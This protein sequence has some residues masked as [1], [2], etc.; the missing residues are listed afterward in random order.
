[1]NDA[2][3]HVLQTLEPQY[4]SIKAAMDEGPK[5]RCDLTRL[6]KSTMLQV[7]EYWDDGIETFDVTN[8]SFLFDDYIDW[9]EK[10]LATWKH[11]R[12]MSWDQWYFRSHKDAEKFV[13]LFNLKWAR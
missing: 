11:V 4:D 5:V 1:V 2:W 3:L 8:Q 13:T 6:E 10:Q 9:I 7:T 12:R